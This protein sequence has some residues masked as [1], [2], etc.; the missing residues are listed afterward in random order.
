MA[1]SV[2]LSII[3]PCKNEETRISSTLDTIAE[4][5]KRVACSV[6]V[7]VLDDGSTDRTSE[8]IEEYCRDHPQFP[9]RLHRNERNI[10]LSNTYVNGAF[11]A[12]GKYCK[13][14]SGDDAEPAELLVT[15]FRRLG[16]ADMIIP[17]HEEM[18]G[19]SAARIAVSKL[20]TFLVNLFSGNTIRY[21]NGGAIHLRY[22]ILRWHSYA[23][24]FGFQADFI[25]RLIDLGASY[26]EVPVKGRHTEK[27]RGGSPFHLRNFVSTAHTL[28][29]ILRRRINRWI[30]GV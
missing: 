24:G 5:L 16:E 13:L 18:K 4:A 9:L 2:D 14:M 3:I 6:D 10:G 25:T 30:F 17:Y 22:N 27:G 21:Y 12:H 28:M 19:K 26:V 20:Y 23:Y 7:L 15:I 29:E 1:D 8:V 11:L